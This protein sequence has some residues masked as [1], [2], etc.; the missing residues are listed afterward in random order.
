MA[1]VS[2]NQRTDR[3]RGDSSRDMAR[4]VMAE[5]NGKGHYSFREK[6]VDASDVQ[7]EL[8]AAKERR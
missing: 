1:K 8:E 6:M 7:D 4:I 2:K 5:K 3:V